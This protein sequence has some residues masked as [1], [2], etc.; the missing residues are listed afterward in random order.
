MEIVVAGASGFLGNAFINYAQNKG[1]KIRKLVRDT[2][3]F[4]PFHNPSTPKNVTEYSWNPTKYQLDPQILSGTDAIICFSGAGIANKLWTKKYRKT[5]WTS[6][7]DPLQ[8]LANAIAQLP[9]KDKPKHLLAASAVG[10]YGSRGSEILTE[11]SMAGKEFLA[12]LCVK[13]ENTAN[14]IEIA[15]ITTLRTG[16]VISK[17]AGFLAPLWK[18]YRCWLGGKIGS[19]KQYLP[20]ISYY[21]YLR[22]LEYILEKQI[23]GAVNMCA[24]EPITNT[25]FNKELAAFLQVKALLPVP[26][27]LLRLILQDMS[28]LALQSAR[29][30]PKKLLD[31]GFAF[32]HPTFSTQLAWIKNN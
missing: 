26:E 32:K 14:T 13:W 16:L 9:E 10:Y 2:K 7:R 23:T 28:F 30:I 22:A 21:D 24:P 25:E 15:H 12:Q 20:T 11:S 5:L 1:W 8:T 4:T 17:N 27:F 19:G 18:I 31:N 29:V 3:R 6:R